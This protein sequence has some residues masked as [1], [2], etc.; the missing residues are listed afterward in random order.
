MCRK[1]LF[2]RAWGGLPA[3][4]DL[5]PQV[6]P[7]APTPAHP[8]EAR[9]R[10]RGGSGVHAW[11]PAGGLAGPACAG[12]DPQTRPAPRKLL[13]LAATRP[14]RPGREFP[15][16]G[17]CR[18][19]PRPSSSTETLTGK[20]SHKLP[21]SPRPCRGRDPRQAPHRS[22]KPRAPGAQNSARTPLGQPRSLRS[23]RRVLPLFLALMVGP[24]Q[25]P[26]P[27][28]ATPSPRGPQG[29]SGASP[30]GLRARSRALWLRLQL[31][32]AP[33]P[34]SS[35]RLTQPAGMGRDRSDQGGT[36]ALSPLASG[37][38][39]WGF[40]LRLGTGG[41]PLSWVWSAGKGSQR[42]GVYGGINRVKATRVGAD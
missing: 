29:P 5:P 11:S 12:W 21:P 2:T 22:G 20:L 3:C 9:G 15:G 37:R 16:W 26:N 4:P 10:S 36:E 41:D 18:E 42:G 39:D 27:T 14:R 25:F 17:Q 40:P 24:G 23:P 7:G 8:E 31:L 33:P 28:L 32:P 34:P 38:G 30:A 13:P 19:G 1:R 6:G 35:C